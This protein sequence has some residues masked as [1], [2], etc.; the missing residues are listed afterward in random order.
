LTK[1]KRKKEGS[2]KPL[3]KNQSKKREMVTDSGGGLSDAESVVGRLFVASTRGT[4]G[5]LRQC[6]DSEL[7]VPEL[8]RNTLSRY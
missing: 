3:G 4:N 7:V 2:R 1:R 5:G 8:R 6:T